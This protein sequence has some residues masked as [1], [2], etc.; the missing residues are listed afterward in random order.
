[1]VAGYV[2][3]ITEKTQEFLIDLATG[4]YAPSWKAISKFGKN[5]SVANGAWEMVTNL[6]ATAPYPW[7]TAATTVRVKAGGDAADTAA[8]AGARTIRVYGLDS[9]AENEIYEDITLAGI[10]ASASTTQSFWRVYR[11]YVLTAGTYATPYNTGAITI[12]NTAGT[13]DLLKIEAGEAQ[14]QLLSYS[15]PSGRSAVI[16]G[17]EVHV[18]ATK[19]ADLRIKYRPNF[20]TVSGSVSAER[21]IY[22]EAGV[23]GEA[24]NVPP[25]PLN[26]LTG[27]A[28]IWIEAFG[29]GAATKVSGAFQL[30]EYPTP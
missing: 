9:T 7:P 25:I 18:E 13:A 1:M 5:L 26:V 8:G 22:F 11:A 24:Q 29:A 23:D 16:F 10:S 19:P 21:V 2:A 28:D 30:F 27:P 12:E 3:K 14:T 20:T 15:I 4:R 6:S 17:F